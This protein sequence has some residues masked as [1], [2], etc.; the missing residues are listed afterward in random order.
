MK[1]SIAPALLAFV[2]SPTFSQT[3]MHKELPYNQDTATS[4]SLIKSDRD[5]NILLA[6]VETTSRRLLIQKVGIDGAIKW[7]YLTTQKE[8]PKER[9]Q[10]MVED[11]FHSIT[12]EYVACLK[13]YGERR[14]SGS[15]AELLVL[16]SDGK[17]SKTYLVDPDTNPYNGNLNVQ[18]CWEQKAETLLLGS[19]FG[20]TNYDRNKNPGS[21]YWFQKLG[22]DYRQVLSRFIPSALRFRSDFVDVLQNNEIFYAIANNGTDSELIKINIESGDYSIMNIGGIARF[23]HGS[24]E[25]KILVNTKEGFEIQEFN[26]NLIITEKQKLNLATKSMPLAAYTANDGSIAILYY[27][28]VGNESRISMQRIDQSYRVGKRMIVKK[29]NPPAVFSMASAITASNKIIL[30]F[31]QKKNGQGLDFSNNLLK[32]ENKK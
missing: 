17:E 8:N 19:I 28:F 16:D 9:S 7:K 32:I 1:N 5:E 25:V 23:L 30:Q 22:S 13:R 15:S 21:V 18:K 10:P 31:Y 6:G 26:K 3:T 11:I 2:I 12:G 4:I 20:G 24:D 27:D 14:A 29:W